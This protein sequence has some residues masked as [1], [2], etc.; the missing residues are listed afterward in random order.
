M[1]MAV[2]SLSRTSQESY[3]CNIKNLKYSTILKGLLLEGTGL[4][5]KQRNIE[6][7]PH[8]PRHSPRKKTSEKQKCIMNHEKIPCASVIAHSITV[9]AKLAL[10]H[11]GSCASA[12][13]SISRSGCTRALTWKGFQGYGGGNG[14]EGKSIGVVGVFRGGVI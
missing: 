8:T 12:S 3:L 4:V 10:S 13:I 5:I 6:N 1:E 14:L 2:L 7:F 11:H 9:I